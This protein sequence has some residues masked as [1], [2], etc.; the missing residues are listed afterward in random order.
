MSY[1]EDID[2]QSRCSEPVPESR[3]TQ[4]MGLGARTIHGRPR[5]R[6]RDKPFDGDWANA[7]V[8]VAE[9]Q[10][11]RR[12]NQH[13]TPSALVADD[14]VIENNR[15]PRR[16]HAMTVSGVTM[17]RAVRQPLNAADSQ[18]HS[19]RSGVRKTQPSRSGSLPHLQLMA[20]REDPEV[21]RGT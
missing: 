13:P 9:G 12:S 1:V 14:D 17:T 20:S 11:G 5:S 8:L 21:Q 3:A 7:A 10:R 19:H 18:A 6:P 15:T 2:C 16:C 4:F